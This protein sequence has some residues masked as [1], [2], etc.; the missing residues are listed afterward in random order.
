MVRLQPLYHLVITHL[1]LGFLLLVCFLLFG[2]FHLL[3]LSLLLHLLD[4][5]AGFGEGFPLGFVC[6]PEIRDL[7][8]SL[9][10]LPPK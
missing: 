3:D 10:Q 6:V 7:G 5:L 8:S 9:L 4:F 2:E 1:V